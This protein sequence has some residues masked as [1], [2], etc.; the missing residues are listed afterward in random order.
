MFMLIV[1]IFGAQLLTE[2]RQAIGQSGQV[3]TLLGCFPDHNVR[4]VCSC[5]RAES[6][7]DVV[8]LSVSDLCISVMVVVVDGRWYRCMARRKI[9][10]V[11]RILIFHSAFGWF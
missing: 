3:E 9:G 1:R 5:L 4:I 7:A 6:S 10:F 2:H 11:L 8:F